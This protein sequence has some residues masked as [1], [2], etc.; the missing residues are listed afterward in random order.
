MTTFHDIEPAFFISIKSY[1]PYFD[2]IQIASLK[3]KFD[4]NEDIFKTHKVNATDKKGKKYTFEIIP[5]GL[6]KDDTFTW[7]GDVN[8]VF[9][10]HMMKYDVD[11]FKHKF[12]SKLFEKKIE[13]S[14]NNLMVIPYFISIISPRFNIIEAYNNETESS[15]IFAVNLGLKDNFDFD[16]F[17]AGLD[18]LIM[19]KNMQDKKVRR[20]KKASK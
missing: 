10:E 8:T 13:F 20:I 16:K 15:F 11:A 14:K 9:Y 3:Y 1:K 12:F 2:K 6:I 7:F 17:V 18:A 5:F 19:M 4:L